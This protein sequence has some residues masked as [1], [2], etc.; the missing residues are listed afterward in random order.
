MYGVV[1]HDHQSEPTSFCHEKFLY[2]WI[3]HYAKAAVPGSERKDNEKLPISGNL[4]Y[5]KQAKNRKVMKNCKYQEKLT[6][7]IKM[8]F[9]RVI[10]AI[11]IYK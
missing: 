11:F 8:G 2:R 4:H 3:I 6:T 7:T 10:W 5:E 1:I 9:E